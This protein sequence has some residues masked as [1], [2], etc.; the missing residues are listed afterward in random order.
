MKLATFSP[1]RQY[2]Y[3]LWRIWNGMFSQGYAVFIGLNP[4]TADENNDDP[5]IRRCIGFAK[6][7]GCIGLCMVNLF[8]FRAT[9]PAVMK[10]QEDPIGPENDETLDYVASGA[11]VIVAAW[12]NDGAFLDRDKKVKAMF[13]NLH[14]LGLTKKGCP[15]HPLYLPKGLKP[16]PWTEA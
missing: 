13:P 9:S 12:G 2:R 8:A 6:D 11:G 14:H 7:W 10:A 16:T 15:R 4:S 1:C 5:T 3:S